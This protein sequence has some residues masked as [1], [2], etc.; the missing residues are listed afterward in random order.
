MKPGYGPRTAT[1]AL[2]HLIEEAGEVQ[3][4]AGK[5]IRFGFDGSYDN[6]ETNKQALLRE[7]HDLELAIIDAKRL[8]Y[9]LPA[10]VCPQCK[11]IFS[12][13]G[14]VSGEHCPDCLAKL[15]KST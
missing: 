11:A 2:G 14:M 8:I 4:A 10:Q 7:I 9:G 13:P 6:G 5:I 1:E 3:Q 15:Y 12:I